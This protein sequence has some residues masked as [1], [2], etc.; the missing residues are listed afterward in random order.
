MISGCALSSRGVPEPRLPHLIITS[1]EQLASTPGNLRSNRVAKSG[2]D[3]FADSCCIERCARC[4]SS[5]HRYP[6]RSDRA[7][8]WGLTQVSEEF[9]LGAERKLT[10]AGHLARLLPAL[11]LVRCGVW[12]PFWAQVRHSRSIFTS[13]P[14]L[15]PAASEQARISHRLTSGRLLLA[16]SCSKVCCQR[17][18]S[19]CCE[20][21]Q[22]QQ[23]SCHTAT[24]LLSGRVAAPQGGRAILQMKRE[25][26][27]RCRT[28]SE[29]CLRS[30]KRA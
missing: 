9:S 28:A 8:S 11:P 29:T 21:A 16:Q 24:R 3:D 19:R 20:A 13:C 10:T 25:A 17:P 7:V 1:N 2:T 23:P 26:P 6:S 27:R 30:L 5:S 4:P 22:R 14:A 18:R 12:R 15:R